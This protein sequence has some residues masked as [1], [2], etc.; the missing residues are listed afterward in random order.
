MRQGVQNELRVSLLG[1]L[2][3]SVDGKELTLG[4]PRQRA[5]LAVLALRANHVVPRSELIDAVWGDEPPASADNGIHTYV[6]GLRRLFEPGRASRAPSQVLLSTDAGYL[7]KLPSDSSDVGMFRAH[8]DDAGR[9]RGNPEEAVSAFDAAL[10][11]WRGV[12]LEGVPGP[13]AAVERARLAEL[14][15]TA[16]EQRAALMLSVGREA[17]VA[18]EL[19]TLVSAHP[20]RERLHGLLMSALY[21]GG[22]QAEALAV[23]TDLRRLLIEELG[24]EPGP[25]L[26]QLHEQ[27]LIGRHEPQPEPV[28]PVL[29]PVQLPHEV[30]D[31]TGREKE[32][33]R[34][35]EAVPHDH[36]PV[37]VAITGTGGVGKTALAV[38]FAHQVASRFPDGQ[39]HVD[40]RGFDASSP[41]V[42]PG[43]ALHQLL[44]SLGV[45][46]ERIPRRPAREVR[47]VPQCPGRQTRAGAARQRPPRRPGAAA[48]AGPFVVDGAGDLAQPPRRPR[49][50]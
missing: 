19:T 35:A 18:G 47:A 15:L 30:R 43:A 20:L 21:R 38:R 2:A 8:L 49:R 46:S 37:L 29:V 16:V 6:A 12:A 22:R 4:P 10:G 9:L 1:A 36:S 50:P 39:L 23:Y 7:L 34:L 45:P 24:I 14:R 32:L 28:A 31:F 27:L 5:V 17:E 26:R 48:A 44:Q 13:F 25:E 11:L 40:L 3:A 41:P 33:Q 42:Q